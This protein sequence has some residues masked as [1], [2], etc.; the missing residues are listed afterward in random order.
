[1]AKFRKDVKALQG[2][3]EI[4]CEMMGF[5]LRKMGL[6]SLDKAGWEDYD[7]GIK[8]HEGT[9]QRLFAFVDNQQPDDAN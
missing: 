1:M 2:A 3:T 6:F 5:S 8:Y 9:K 4:F 7:R